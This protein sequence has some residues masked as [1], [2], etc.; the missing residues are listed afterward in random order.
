MK[1]PKFGQTIASLIHRYDD[2]RHTADVLLQPYKAAPPQFRRRLYLAAF[3]L[4]LFA[5]CIPFGFYYAITTP[6]RIVPLAAPLAIMLAAIVWAL[7]D[8]DSKPSPLIEYLFFAFFAAVMVWPN[9]LAISLPGLPWITLRRLFGFPI[10]FLFLVSISTSQTFRQKLN[11]Y[12]K[13]APLVAIACATIFCLQIITL[14]LSGTIPVS[15]QKIIIWQTNLTAILFISAYVFSKPGRSE[16]WL[17]A[18]W[19]LCLCL[20]LIAFAETSR[21]GIL[22]VGHIPSFLKIDT[23]NVNSM[24]SAAVR[25][26]TGVYRVKGPASTPLGLAELL[27]LSLP[28][29][30]HIAMGRYGLLVRLLA[31]A[32]VP[33]MIHVIILTDSRLG[34]VGTIM[35]VLLYFAFWAVLRWRRKKGDLF[36]PAL[37]FSSPF[38]VVAGAL[39]TVFVRRLHVMVWGGGAQTASNLA[40]S[41]QIEGGL[42]MILKNPLGYGAGQAAQTLGYRGG[43]GVLTIDNYYLSIALEYGV[44]GFVAFYG[45][46]LFAIFKAWERSLTLTESEDRE[47]D[48]FIPLAVSLSNFVVIKGVFSQQDNHPIVFMMVGMVL[49]LAYRLRSSRHAESPPSRQR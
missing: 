17:F 32:S 37:L 15:V 13:S 8:T 5:I 40:R 20:C 34:M 12:H 41:A 29:V 1:N 47:F 2:R 19:L 39:A 48:L 35:S 16:R 31:A 9:Y 42:P 49:A 7:P 11:E 25:S 23:E 4:A 30:I 18:L 24:L 3:A 14:P 43:G 21:K 45:M 33:V 38:V 26:A 36:A 28:F 44:I 46:F 6:Y 10:V 27:A 22:W